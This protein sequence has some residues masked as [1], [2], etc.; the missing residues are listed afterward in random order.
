MWVILIIIISIILLV[1]VGELNG[2]CC[3]FVNTNTVVKARYCQKLARIFKESIL[4][5][6]SAQ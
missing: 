2:I 4:V 5:K 3:I 1:I 6:R